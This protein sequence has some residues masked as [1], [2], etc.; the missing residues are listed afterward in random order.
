[1]KVILIRDVATL[2]KEGDVVE[3]SDGHAR[4]FLFPQNLAVSATAD[5]LQKR[6]EKL[7]AEKKSAHKKLSVAADLAKQLDGQEVVLALKTSDAGVLFAAVNPKQIVKALKA[8][9]LKVKPEQIKIA[10][11]IKDVGEYEVEVQLDQGFE[12]TIRVI[13]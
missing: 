4:N 11:P 12:V 9:S 10:E 2:G 1:M 13:I 3:V 6:A 5:V 7:Q 8:Q